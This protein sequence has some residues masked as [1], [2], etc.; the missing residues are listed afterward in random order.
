MEIGRYYLKRGQYTAAINRFRTVVE[1]YQT[2]THIEEALH[3][4]VESYLALGVVPEA[5][6]AAAILGHNFQG[7]QWYRDSYTLLT[8]QEIEAMPSEEGGKSWLSDVY[9]RVIKGEWL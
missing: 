8:G 7:S 6:K 3:R 5:Q 4:L 1:Q 2:T 9:R